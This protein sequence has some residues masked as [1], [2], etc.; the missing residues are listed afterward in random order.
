VEFENVNLD[1]IKF[2]KV[3]NPILEKYRNLGIEDRAKIFN[4]MISVLQMMLNVLP[5]DWMPFHISIEKS[6]KNKEATK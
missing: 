2:T 4:V 6:L 1:T 5:E 3:V